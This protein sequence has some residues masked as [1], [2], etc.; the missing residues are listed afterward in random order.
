[1]RRRDL[2]DFLAREIAGRKLAKRP[3][4]VAIDGRCAS[5][6]TMLAD[7]LAS[8]LTASN[9]EVLR[10]SVDGFHHPRERRYR[11]GEYSAAGYYEDA[12]DYEAVIRLLLSPLSGDVFPV[13]CRQ[14]ARDVR[15]DMPDIAP[16]ASVGAD[17]VLLFEGLFLFRRELDTYWDFR[18]LLD[19]DAATSLRR[20]IERDSGIIGPAEVVQR[21]YE[22]RYEPAW[23]MYV[24]AEHPESK[25]DVII[26][27]RDFQSPKLIPS[28]NRK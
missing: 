26:D 7:E 15:T 18:V 21:K 12:W 22:L 4:K 25:A 1:M 27:N 5:G 11:K 17:T 3:L 9:L 16:P 23:Q 19:I 20:A 13:L 8:K 28:P 10:P 24:D 2:L 6:K 14:V